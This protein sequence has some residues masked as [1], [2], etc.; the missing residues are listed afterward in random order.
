MNRF[1]QRTALTE[2][3][4][5]PDVPFRDWEVCLKELNTINTL[6]GGHQITIS[7]V[8]QL[9]GDNCH[10]A[11]IGCGGGDNLIA[12]HRWNKNKHDIRYTG[13]DLNQSCID[14]AAVH[15][16]ELPG[17]QLICSDYRLVDFGDSPPD[18]I[19]SSLFC[20]HFSDDQ[21][22]EML[23]WLQANTRKGF[24]INDLH[25]HPLAFHSIKW[26]TRWFSRS[27]LI[28][29]DAPIS[30]MRGF[31][32]EEWKKLFDRAGIRHYSIRWRWAFRYLIVVKHD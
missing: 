1:A 5:Q 4:D 20:H 25:R 22:V 12:V 26:L 28:R 24:V 3:I 11:E 13:I 14:F 21:L 30:V 7:G 32:K 19:F 29:N 6:L 18:I 31:T 2:L 16:R 9:I 15:C 10:I 8:K 27:Y 17:L 23:R